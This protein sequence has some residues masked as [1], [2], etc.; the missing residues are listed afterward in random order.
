MY[1]KQTNLFKLGSG[2]SSLFTTNFHTN[3]SNKQILIW[4]RLN[5]VVGAYNIVDVL[6][7]KVQIPN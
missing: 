7:F 4:K 3:V 5:S 6:Y 1:T 2:C